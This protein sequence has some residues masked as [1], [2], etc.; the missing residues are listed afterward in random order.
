MTFH[1]LVKTKLDDTI[2]KPKVYQVRVQ[3]AVAFEHPIAVDYKD[4]EYT[5]EDVRITSGDCIISFWFMPDSTE[6]EI[7]EV[8]I[9]G[10]S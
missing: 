6:E 5:D 8:T 9:V 1:V 10:R 2:L 4:F 3:S 7:M